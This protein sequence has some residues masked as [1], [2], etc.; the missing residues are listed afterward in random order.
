MSNIQNPQSPVCLWIKGFEE[1]KLRKVR[2]MQLTEHK[3][4]QFRLRELE[5]IRPEINLRQQMHETDGEEAIAVITFAL[6]ILMLSDIKG[7][8][9]Y[10]RPGAR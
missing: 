10:I 8:L 6:H 4:A 1:S 7:G 5:Q 2:L 3:Y 9:M